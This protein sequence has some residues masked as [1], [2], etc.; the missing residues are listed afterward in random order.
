MESVW[1]QCSLKARASVVDKDVV[2]VIDYRLVC[3]EAVL[4]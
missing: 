4:V 2:Y 3:V 1:K